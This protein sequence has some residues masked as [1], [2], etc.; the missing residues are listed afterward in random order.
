MSSRSSWTARSRP[1]SLGWSPM[2]KVPGGDAASARSGSCRSIDS[3]SVSLSCSDF[4]PP[5]VVEG[6]HLPMLRTSARRG[7]LLPHSLIP[8]PELRPSQQTASHD[9]NSTGK[10]ALGMGS[11]TLQSCVTMGTCLG[12]R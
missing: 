3:A 11:H 2:A 8:D 6:G 1:K 10:L 12:V 7:E 5:H 4:P 9:E